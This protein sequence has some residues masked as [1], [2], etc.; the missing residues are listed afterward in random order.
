MLSVPELTLLV[1][2]RVGGV[3]FLDLSCVASGMNLNLTSDDMAGIKRQGISADDKNYY[4]PENIPYQAT[5][6]E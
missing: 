1:E 6:P 5:Q 2:R 3:E 4:S